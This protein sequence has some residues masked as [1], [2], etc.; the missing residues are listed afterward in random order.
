MSANTSYIRNIQR[1]Q[2]EYL[3]EI[4]PF[5][6]FLARL[7]GMQRFSIILR[8]GQIDEIRTAWTPEAGAARDAAFGCIDVIQKRY[9][10]GLEKLARFC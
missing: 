3:R 6:R 2:Q 5:T 7:Y 1:L 8:D 9:R 10:S 4:E